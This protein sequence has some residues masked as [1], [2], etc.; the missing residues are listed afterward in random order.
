MIDERVKDQNETTIPPELVS[1]YLAS[2]I[3]KGN[4]FGVIEIHIER[5]IVRVKNRATY[6]KADLEELIRS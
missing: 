5:K 4:H 1:D 6:L 3:T 2:L